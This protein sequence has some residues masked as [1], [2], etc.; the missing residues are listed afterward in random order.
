MEALRVLTA[1]RPQLRQLLRRL[2]AFGDDVQAEV[3]RER[4]DRADHFQA[5]ILDFHAA[6]ERAI[7][8][9]RVGSKPMQITERGIAGAEIIEAPLDAD[10]V[11]APQRDLGGAHVSDEGALGDLQLQARRLQPGL[12]EHC[13]HVLRQVGVRELAPRH[14]DAHDARGLGAEARLPVDHPAARFGEDQASQLAN[15]AGVFSDG[16]EFSRAEQAAKRVTPAR[17]RLESGDASAGDAT[18]GW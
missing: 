12:A 9:D 4:D 8:L 16:D 14:V 18:I 5:A 6:D 17:Q 11:H 3:V 1:D 10:G 13:F 15:Q 7:D 2:D